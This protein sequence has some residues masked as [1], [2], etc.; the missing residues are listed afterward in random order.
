M[1][2]LLHAAAAPAARTHP[3][4]GA[5]RQLFNVRMWPCKLCPTSPRPLPP[6]PPPS[7]PPAARR[8]LCQPGPPAVPL[9]RRPQLPAGGGAVHRAVAGGGQ[10]GGPAGRAARGRGVGWHAHRARQLPAGRGRPPLPPPRAPPGLPG[11]AARG[12]SSARPPGK[13]SS[14]GGLP[15]GKGAWI[16]RCPPPLPCLT[17]LPLGGAATGR[18]PCPA[19]WLPVGAGRA[20]GGI[21]PGKRPVRLLPLTGVGGGW[22]WG[23]GQ[24]AACCFCGCGPQTTAAAPGA[25]LPRIQH[26]STHPQP[27]AALVNS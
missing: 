16:H 22:G 8:L 13:G 1:A 23:W 9:G 20:G 27:W 21:L 24:G 4:P 3:A 17:V 11:A 26:S 2:W 18:G 5:A 7:P 10:G 19:G 25:S 15:A 12:A 14:R 6:G